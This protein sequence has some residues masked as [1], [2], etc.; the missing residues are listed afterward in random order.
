MS[1]R[2]LVPA[3]AALALL[4]AGCGGDGN[5]N[6]A[7]ETVSTTE[8]ANG[9]CGSITAWTESLQSAAEPLTGGDI[10]EEA[11]REAA[12]DVETATNEFT[13]D[14]QELGR[15]D[16]EAGQ[17]AKD[18][19]DG[20]DEELDDDL[21]KLQSTADDATPSN[22]LSTVSTVSTTLGEM[23]QQVASTFQE[24]DQLDASNELEQAFED[25]DSCDEIRSAQR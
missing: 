2:L 9:L 14:L 13:Q 7:D 21:Q 3:L 11:L 22:I 15:P 24:L 8:W 18:L 12:D 23:A 19:L 25:A 6:G 5:G 1:R 16:T 17:E 10:S 20:L 4:A